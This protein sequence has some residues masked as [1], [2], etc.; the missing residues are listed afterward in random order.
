MKKKILL[1][2]GVTFL[3][4]LI[5]TI[6]YMRNG[7]SKDVSIP[8]EV[9]QVVPH[10]AA[11]RAAYRVFPVSPLPA[12]PK[13][14]W[15]DADKEQFA[16]LLAGQK[17]NL[18]IAP[19]Q[20]RGSGFDRSTRSLMAAYLSAVLEDDFGEKSLDPYM[21]QR[22]LGEGLR[23]IEREQIVRLANDTGAL[24]RLIIEVGH[25]GRGASFRVNL[26]YAQRVS[27]RDAWPEEKTHELII[28]F[29]ENQTY[30]E[31]FRIQAIPEIAKTFGFQSL[32]AT[33]AKSQVAMTRLPDNLNQAK[34]VIVEN[35]LNESIL[36]QVLATISPNQPERARESLFE[37]SLIALHRSKVKDELTTYLEARANFYLHSRPAALK[38]LGQPKNAEGIA[39][40]EFL[41]GNLPEM[42]KAISDVKNEIWRLMLE[43]ELQ[44]LRRAYDVT[45][46][47]PLPAFVVTALNKR[48]FWQPLFLRRLQEK[49]GWS[50]Q[51]NV[52]IKWQLDQ[53]LPI[54]G[55]D[56]ETRVRNSQAKGEKVDE[57]ALG[58]SAL[59]HIQR[60]RVSSLPDCLSSH[61]ACINYA[62]LD[63]LEAG[64][65]SN[66]VKML[67]K[68]GD[69]QGSYDRAEKLAEYLGSYLS[70]NTDY[71][72]AMSKILR[73]KLNSS[74]AESRPLIIEKINN[75]LSLA[76]YWEQGQSET[77]GS[78]SKLLHELNLKSEPFFSV[79]GDDLP[80]RPYWVDRTWYT[81]FT[82]STEAAL[83]KKTMEEMK[84]KLDYAQ[85]DINLALYIA[86][87]SG[88][89]DADLMTLKNQVADRFSG[90]PQHDKL[91]GIIEKVSDTEQNRIKN[92]ELAIRKNP[93][94]WSNYHDYANYLINAKGNYLHAREILL[95]YPGFKRPD[96]YDVVA[97]SSDAADAGNTFF[98]KGY[99]EDAKIFYKIAAD[100][101]TGS[102]SSHLGAI[103]LSLLRGDYEKVSALSLHNAQRYDV[104]WTYGDYM[105]WQFVFGKAQHG[106][107]T[108]NQIKT[109]FTSPEA[110]RA[111]DIGYR[112]DQ[113]SWADIAA[114]LLKDEIKNIKY[115]QY[116]PALILAILH[117]SVDRMPAAD[118]PEVMKSIEGKAIGNYSRRP[119]F[120]ISTDSHGETVIPPSPFS[121]REN[122]KI[123]TPELWSDSIMF[124]DAYLS[125]RKQDYREAAAKFYTMEAFYPINY[126]AS[127][128][129]YAYTLVYFSWASA[130]SGDPYKLEAYLDK[131]GVLS[132]AEHDYY[133][134]KAIFTG[135]RGETPKALQY[136][137]LAFNNRG[138]NGIRPILKEYQWAETCELLFEATND[139]TYRDLALK[140][141][142]TYQKLNPIYAWAYAMEAKLTSSPE[143][144]LRALGIALYLDPQSERANAF[145]ESLRQQAK[146]WFASNNPFARAAARNNKLAK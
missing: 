45:L 100:L 5:C 43:I 64:L 9:K 136:L 121:S 101:D 47:T 125:F 110:W 68:A 19:I 60:A 16:T 113:R 141:S 80:L 66:A 6:F 104:A 3:I 146:K 41:N 53:S 93:D 83:S 27:V 40:R 112:I 7:S 138:R 87:T 18:F 108:F 132:S 69:Y 88:A 144:R 135:L 65:I 133:L 2:T 38:S 12:A 95:K 92:Y 111:A 142:K 139:K 116:K 70:G 52:Q 109:R 30:A 79:F 114:W 58:M 127:L 102:G 145:P 99:T 26:H 21:V 131:I 97:V 39:F 94:T 55:F 56:L 119:T 71:A 54:K 28:P 126:E 13:S 46:K 123:M 78:A 122:T 11:S 120:T 32:G 23:K 76:A 129:Q 49:D 31:T 74:T 115:E 62:Y 34:S 130:K 75:Y 77:S 143:D 137:N 33:D 17:A 91:I 85:S 15:I 90:S 29:V 124:A 1:C 81:S 25:D 35:R 96:V 89:T 82:A 105:A 51:S 50:V 86:Q 106:W 117:N 107:D 98:W 14:A 44:D 67:N 48:P 42:E 72:L 103:R 73:G 57:I 61:F 84:L 10:V 59:E 8:V 22:A 140:W 134:S 118:L 37:Q 36:Y 24:K 4:L 20:I 128:N 63:V